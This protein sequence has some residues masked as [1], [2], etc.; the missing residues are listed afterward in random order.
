MREPMPEI[1]YKRG[2]CI[3]CGARTERQAETK[4]QPTQDQTG[5]WSCAGDFDVTGWSRVP[6]AESIREL[7]AWCDREGRRMDTETTNR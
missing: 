6:T 3:T 1:R 7:D 2:P 4:C 5:E